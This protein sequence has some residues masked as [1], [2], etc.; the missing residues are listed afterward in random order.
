MLGVWAT[1]NIPQALCTSAFPAIHV[2]CWPK[3]RFQLIKHINFFIKPADD[4]I[5]LWMATRNNHGYI[6]SY[7]FSFFHF[8]FYLSGNNQIF[9]L[10]FS[11]VL[12]LPNAHAFSS[13][14]P[15]Y[16]VWHGRATQESPHVY[17]S[18]VSF[19]LLPKSYFLF[20]RCKD[21]ISFC[22]FQIICKLFAFRKV[23][24]YYVKSRQNSSSPKFWRNFLTMHHSPCTIH[25]NFPAAMLCQ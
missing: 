24:F 13:P 7:S 21:M 2:R 22:N 17:V 19:L 14:K 25:H 3:L 10:L 16:A 18:V 8:A 6:L 20:S 1:P 4:F 5:Q 11:A 23:H 9:L 15:T 12:L